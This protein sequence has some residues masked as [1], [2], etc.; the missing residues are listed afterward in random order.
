VRPQQHRRQRAARPHP[1]SA[2]TGKQQNRFRIN[3]GADL[4]DRGIDQQAALAG[5]G[6][7]QDTYQAAYGGRQNSTRF[8]APGE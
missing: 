1:Q 3:T 4:S 6:S 5:A 2:G 7:A 8:D